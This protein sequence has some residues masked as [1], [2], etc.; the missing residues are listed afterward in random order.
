MNI[1]EVAQAA[2][3][4]VATVSRV[5]NH[6]ELVAEKTR[7]RVLAVLEQK[8]Y[9]PNAELRTRSAKRK[10]AIALVIP[11]LME[12]RLTLD[13]V[14]QIGNAKNYG[15]QLCVTDND[16][17]EL[18][19][20]VRALAAQQ[21][22]GVI[23]AGQIGSES[24]YRT[25]REAGI[26]VVCINSLKR[27]GNEDICYINYGESAG[28]LAQ[29][30]VESGNRSAVLILSD[31]YSGCREKFEKGFRE[32][33]YAAG[34]PEAS[35]RTVNAEESFKG[36]AHAM[37]AVLTAN[38]LPDLI[39]A[40]YDE[41]AIGAMKAAQEQKISIPKQLRFMGFFDT[42]VSSAVTPELTSIEQPTY[43]LGVAS[44]R[45]LFD[46]MEDQDYFDVESQ[47]IVLKGRLK[48]RR[49]C[50]NKKT[51]YELYD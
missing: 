2:G 40:Q 26:P 8:R 46:I 43:R 42:P 14:R 35:L 47:E 27:G 12:Y 45:R 49:S 33:W 15:V 32:T 31:R 1:H 38:A 18:I 23:L 21:I 36:G 29:Y 4:S 37:E 6:P 30:A 34:L 16:E 22:D 11:S 20:N 51:I 3:V 7:A 19:R 48:I 13:G 39:V 50:G 24:A 25:L 44:A 10:Q 5:V 28:K 9:A 17:P 41:M